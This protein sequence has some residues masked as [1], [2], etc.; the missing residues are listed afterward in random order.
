M[1]NITVFELEGTIFYC[2]N[3]VNRS[4]ARVDPKTIVSTKIAKPCLA[5]VSNKKS[6]L[7]VQEK[8]MHTI[9]SLNLSVCMDSSISTEFS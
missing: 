6:V 7:K 3:Q 9:C 1:L 8:D 5:K 2:T 4:R